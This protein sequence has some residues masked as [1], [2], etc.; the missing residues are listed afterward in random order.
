MR[1]RYGSRS[2]LARAAAAL[3]A[4]L[5]VLLCTSGSLIHAHG[6]SAGDDFLGVAEAVISGPRSQAFSPQASTNPAPL[7]CLYCEWQANSVS[8]ALPAQAIPSL[9]TVERTAAPLVPLIFRLQPHG[10]SSRAPPVA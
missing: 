8:A 4:V 7:H 5:Y 3:V 6:P 9:Q 10:F 1:K 2:G